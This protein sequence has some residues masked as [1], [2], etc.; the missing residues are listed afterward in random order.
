MMEG[1]WRSLSF[2]TPG[3]W[4]QDAGEMR[5]ILMESRDDTTGGSPITKSFPVSTCT[6]W[7][8]NFPQARCMS[9]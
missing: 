8:L 7:Y 5:S 6:S 4:N 1:K 9:L 3:V 2:A